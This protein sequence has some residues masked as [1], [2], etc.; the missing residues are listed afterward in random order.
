MITKNI[1]FGAI[2]GL[3]LRHKFTEVVT[4]AKDDHKCNYYVI[5]WN[6][7]IFIL[8]HGSIVAKVTELPDNYDEDVVNDTLSKYITLHK[9]YNSRLVHLTYEYLCA[10]YNRLKNIHN[11]YTSI[12]RS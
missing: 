3:D 4:Q 7:S 2:S 6:N 8:K 12:F 11:K 10:E 5:T 1:N 9:V